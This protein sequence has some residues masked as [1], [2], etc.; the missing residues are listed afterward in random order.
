V[1]DS[2]ERRIISA[3]FGLEG[4]TPKT[5]ETV[6]RKFGVTRERIRQLQNGALEK[7]R[8]ALARRERPIG[9]L[10]PRAPEG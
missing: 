9:G 7:L 8:R 4:E 3:R 10:L 5:L 6:G 2:R 1:L